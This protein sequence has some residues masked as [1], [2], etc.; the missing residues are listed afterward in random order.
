[1]TAERQVVDESARVVF[2]VARLGEAAADMLERGGEGRFSAVGRDLARVGGAGGQLE[3]GHGGEPVALADAAEHV[4]AA[5]Q[6]G[7]EL[8]L[9]HA[10]GERQIEAVD[11]LG[12]KLELDALRVRLGH[13]EDDAG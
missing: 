7:I 10:S 5:G 13:V 2:L 6:G 3:L 11:R 1:L 9:Q 12:R 4:A 8:G